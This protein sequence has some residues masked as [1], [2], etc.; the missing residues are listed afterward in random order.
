M[1]G[2]EVFGDDRGD[3]ARCE[4]VQI[5]RILDR[6]ADRLVVERYSR[7]PPITCSFQ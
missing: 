3:V 4:R 6:D 1:R 5:E 7:G 2:V